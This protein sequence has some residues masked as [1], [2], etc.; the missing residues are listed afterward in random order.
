MWTIYKITNLINQKT[1]IGQAINVSKRWS[2]HRA[3]AI[4]NHPV[5]PIHYALI[6]YG[7]ENFDFEA[8]ASCKTQ[9]DANFIET[10]L[11]K[12]YNS[13]IEDG[14][15]YNATLGGMNAPKSE[16]WKAHMRIVMIPVSA[17]RIAAETPE[18]KTNRYLKVSNTMKGMDKIP[19][20]GRKKGSTGQINS[21]KKLSKEIIEL[22][23]LEG[24]LGISHRKIAIT[25]NICRSSVS[26]IINGTYYKN[27]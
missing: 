23:V 3:A 2:D 15:G 1:Y 16:K 11:V 4:H 17:A 25:Y 7:L 27:F 9:D 6:K 20:S 10:E 14:K 18:A 5:Q 19:G 26:R 24:K 22:I 12:Q 13:Y 8:I 21:N